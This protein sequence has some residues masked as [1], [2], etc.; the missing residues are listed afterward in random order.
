MSFVKVVAKNGAEYFYS[1]DSSGK[2][3][4]VSKEKANGVK[5]QV[6][7]NKVAKKVAKGVPKKTVNKIVKKTV[8]K[9]PSPEKP[10]KKAV[11]ESKPKISKIP[12]PLG[13]VEHG[14]IRIGQTRR[15]HAH[16]TYPGYETISAWSRGKAPWKDLSPFTIGPVKFTND[17]GEKDSAKIFEN[18]WQS[19]KVW[20]KVGKQNQKDKKTKED[21]WVWPAETH[22]GKDGF[23]NEKWE[24]WHNALL[25]NEAPVRRPNGKAIPKYAWWD[26]EKLDILEARRQIYI[27]FL[28][29]LYRAHPTYQKLLAKVRSGTNIML[30][31]PD[32]ALLDAYPE[33]MPVDLKKLES[34]IG[35]TNYAKEGFPKAYRPFGHSF[36]I[37]MCLLED[38][39]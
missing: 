10:K 26:G 21:V 31:E 20:E 5:K 16:P 27:P 22:I 39:A 24:K 17:N 1:V 30:V 38:L 19:F 32:G 12:K 28:K 25:H 14:Q 4:R 36:V 2:K 18:F 9:V 37:A 13:M 15:A 8:K 6:P 34:L 7:V 11:P 23:P 33:G 29:V 35:E 3:T